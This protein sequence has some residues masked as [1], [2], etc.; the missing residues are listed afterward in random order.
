MPSKVSVIT[1]V[2]NGARFIDQYFLTLCN[3]TYDNVELIIVDDGSSDDTFDLVKEKKEVLKKKG[4][5]I[6]VL[7]QDN[8]GAAAAVNNAL[9]VVTGDYLMLFD[10]DDILYPDNIKVK[11]LFLDENPEFG[12][13]RCNGY[14]VFESD[15]NS[16]NKLLVV[17]DK[18]KKN[19]WIF[20]DLIYARTNNWPG[21]YMIRFSFFRK[22]NP[23]LNIY[24]SQYGQNLQIMLP[25]A[26]FYK[27]GFIDMPL[28]K[29]VVY[30]NSHSHT[31][32]KRRNIQ[33]A[34]GYLENRIKVIGMLKISNKEKIFYIDY[35]IKRKHILEILG[36]I[37]IKASKKEVLQ[38]IKSSLLNECFIPRT[39]LKGLK[40]VIFG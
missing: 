8:Q 9:K 35:L 26:R 2:F 4:W 31:K 1:P 16:K 37:N 11:A 39:L 24:V 10:I 30:G 33:L 19:E 29:Y 23:G 13:V 34:L 25:I 15:L 14:M 7:K 21:S 22:Q 36:L 32:D 27:S 28:M 20:D 6:I 18:E 5:N 3:Q 12:M 17:D 40:Y 38:S